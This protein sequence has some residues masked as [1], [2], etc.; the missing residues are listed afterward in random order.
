MF[1]Q[2]AHTQ[3]NAQ[4]IYNMLIVPRHRTRHCP[5]TDQIVPFFNAPL[6]LFTL[7]IPK[8]LQCQGLGCCNLKAMS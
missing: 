1:T 4:H 8:E 5:L 6:N 2:S 3:T 7:P